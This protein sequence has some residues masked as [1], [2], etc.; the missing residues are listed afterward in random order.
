M[1]GCKC[2]GVGQ[3]HC[4]LRCCLDCRGGCCCCCCCRLPG[5]HGPSDSCHGRRRAGL[6][7]R[8]CANHHIVA[9]LLPLLRLQLLLHACYACCVFQL[10]QQGRQAGA[11]AARPAAAHHVAHA[12]PAPPFCARQQR[13]SAGRGNDSV[14]NQTLLWLLLVCE[15]RPAARHHTKTQRGRAHPP[16]APLPAPETGH[17]ATGVPQSALPLPA[18]LPPTDHPS[19]GCCRMRCPAALVAAA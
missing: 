16:K 14:G 3:R 7:W 9:L 6:R 19:V 8:Q 1:R 17:A 5:W 11:A 10:P 12:S 15:C 13:Q 18:Q 2:R 4:R